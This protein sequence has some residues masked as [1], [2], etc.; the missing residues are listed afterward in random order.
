MKFNAGAKL[1][2]TQTVAVQR[3]GNPG[4]VLSILEKGEEGVVGT[5]TEAEAEANLVVGMFRQNSPG[6]EDAIV[7]MVI[8]ERHW[9]RYFQVY[10]GTYNI[11]EEFVVIEPF[12]MKSPAPEGGIPEFVHTWRGETVRVTFI[13]EEFVGEPRVELQLEDRTSRFGVFKTAMAQSELKHYIE[14]PADEN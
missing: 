10:D 13:F 4:N 12:T 1:V 5:L 14:R 7:R 8:E 11:G 9:S 3:E 6:G 2:L